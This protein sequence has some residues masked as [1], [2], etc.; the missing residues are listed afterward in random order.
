M[1]TTGKPLIG[2][3]LDELKQLV[4][5]Y[6]L[7]TFTAK[8]IADWIYRKRVLHIADMTNLSARARELLSQQW[9]VGVAEPVERRQS[10][11]GTVKYLFEAGEGGGHYIESV[12]IP[13]G[14]R[15]TLCISSQIGCQMGCTFCATGRQGYK[16]NL[17]TA[18]ILNQVQ[19]IEQSDS[20][21]NIVFMGM[22]EPLN[23]AD[24]V[25]KAIA[26]MTA[27]YGYGWSPKRITLS[28]VGI[29]PQLARALDESQC[30]IA[31][32]IHAPNAA[33][34]AQLVPAEKAYPMHDTLELLRRHDFSHQRRL[35]FEYTLFD[36][37]NDRKEDALEL[38][39][40]LQ[41][42]DCHINLI[43]FHAIP[44]AGLRPSP[45]AAME[46]FQEVLNQKRFP[47][48]IRRSRGQDIEAA[49]GL[50]SKIK[51][52]QL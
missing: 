49:C 33:L 32:S 45:R 20:L 13:D 18:E 52:T 47:T 50:L 37:V 38:A 51:Q 14:D 39:H 29:T 40:N 42:L 27:D 19:S 48:T 16:G 43:P 11:D 34:R 35:S 9:C 5:A 24:A 17:T 25:L 22:G 26:I 12:Y 23:N 7:P 31:V 44:D 28:T 3:T 46:A 1:N 15:A 10:K 41:G 2:Q 30:Q 8:Q 21:T 6:G 36:G 4:A